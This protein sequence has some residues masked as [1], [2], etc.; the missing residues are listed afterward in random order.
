MTVQ[1]QNL[2]ADAD[3]HEPKGA[4]SATSGQVY[5]SDG[6]G[7]GSF[8][9]LTLPYD[10]GMAFSGV[11]GNSEIMLR[12]AIVREVTL[13]ANFSGA[14]GS[15]GTTA[16]ATTALDVQDD[17]ISIGTISISTGDVFTFTTTGG[18]S[19][20]ITAGSI[21]T[22]VNQATADGTAANISVTFKGTAPRA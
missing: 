17:G 14:V 16:T 11:P 13:G 12:L 15:I 1:H 5:V 22:I 10:L 7:S 18:T 4:V 19:K 21:L 9:D 2:T 3:L 20:V 8:D 6:A